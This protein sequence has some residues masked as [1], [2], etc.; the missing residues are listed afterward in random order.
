MKA[1]EKPLKTL[2]QKN[3][4]SFLAKDKTYRYDFTTVISNGM[5]DYELEIEIID[6]LKAEAEEFLKKGIELFNII[7]KTEEVKPKTKKDLEWL[8]P[9]KSTSNTS[10]KIDWILANRV[11]YNEKIL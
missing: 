2:R 8:N 1:T 7:N 6:G 3:R 5:E 11:G 10:K 9:I 4:Y